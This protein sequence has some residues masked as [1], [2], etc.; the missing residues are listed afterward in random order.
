MNR[1]MLLGFCSVMSAAVATARSPLLM[2]DDFGEMH[3][4]DWR[5]EPG[6]PDPQNP[7]IEGELPWDQ[8]GV[9]IHGSVFKDPIDKLW[10]AYLVCTPAEEFPELQPENSGKPW[11]SENASHRR[12]CLFESRD[13]IHW[14]RPQ[15][16]NV[17]FGKHKTT[18]IIFDVNDGVS[19][20]SSILVDPTDRA[21][22]YHMYV[23]RE[24]WGAVKGKAPQG[25]GYYRYQSKDGRGWERVGDIINQ[26][27]HG[28][29]CF[30]YKTPEEGYFAY[31]RLGSPGKPTDHVPAYED[32]P[33]R[34]CYRAVSR[35]GITWERDP[36]MLL[37]NDERDHRDVQYQ[38]CVPVKVPGGYLAMVTMYLPLTQ[39][40][41]LRTAASRDGKHWWF[42][43]RRPS[44]D[45]APLG[46]YG[47]GMMWQSQYPIV[48]GNRLYIYYGGTEG[49]H[50]QIHDTRAPSKSIGYQETV[51]DHGGHFIPF[52]AALCRVS[53]RYDRMY[54]LVSS[55]GGPTIGTATTI[56]RPLGGKKLL[57]N[58]ATKAAK[59]ASRPGLDAGYL[60][61]ELLDEKD[62]PLPGFARAECPPLRGDGAEL[63][64]KWNGGEQMP[65]AAK[66]ARF[67]LKRAFLYGFEAR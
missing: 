61:V 45:N 12:I 59:K 26:P 43:D 51:V 24:S 7:L 41:N 20:Y 3:L 23:L 36:D 28:D 35:D 32:F 64:V 6:T 47:G 55:A 10:K 50:R 65:A 44:F 30:F 1:W 60:Q 17:P 42:P 2:P 16:A 53:W 8:G 19:A 14:T 66:K 31:Y 46:D 4:V 38:E 29:L 22:P 33:R 13:G 39:T 62:Q 58:L 49:R 9:G 18:N 52:N 15:L 37:T 21:W 5:V 63:K 57:V 56:S 34:S 54:A 67:Y 27:M 40:L 25:N 11:A 48:E